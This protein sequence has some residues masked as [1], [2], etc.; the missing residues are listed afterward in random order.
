[1]TGGLRADRP[2]LEVTRDLIARLPKTDLH[3]HLD[4]SLRPATLLE[5][6][7]ERGVDLPAADPDGLEA[8]MHVTDAQD[9]VDYLDRFRTTLSVLQDEDALERVAYELGEDAA[10]ENV[11]YMEVRYSPA[12]NT[13]RGLSHEQVVDATL[14]GFGRAER[15]HGIRIGLIICGIRNMSPAVTMALADLTVGY[16]G[17][18]V[19]AM[20]LAGPENNHPP[21]DHREAFERVARAN[22]PVTVHAGEAFGPASIHQAI[23]LCHA[24]RIGHG[25]RL[26]EDPDLEQYVNDRRITLECCPTSNVQTGVVPSLEE[27]PIRDYYD[28]GIMVTIN[29]DNRLMSGVTVTEEVWRTQQAAGFSWAQLCDVVETGFRSAF[30]PYQ[31]RRR[32]LAEV[33]A[34]IAEIEAAA[35]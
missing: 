18:G 26:R 15:D 27:H 32:L 1:V 4:G 35:A 21:G 16:K 28:R 20:D 13:E 25:T 30:L 8:F 14:R 31:E 6:A 2:G 19:V 24:N 5:L 10:G 11:R 29:T 34:E 3:V 7:G 17:R 9:L 12:L 22:M 23:H 33:R